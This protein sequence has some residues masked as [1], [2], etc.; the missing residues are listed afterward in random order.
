MMTT[1]PSASQFIQELDVIISKASQDSDMLVI[2]GLYVILWAKFERFILDIIK[3]AD[4]KSHEIKLFHVFTKIKATMANGGQV[5]PSHLKQWYDN[6]DNAKELPYMSFSQRLHELEVLIGGLK[7]NNKKA[8]LGKLK[9]DIL[10]VIKTTRDEIAH[11]KSPNELDAVID[12]ET[13]QSAKD[14]FLK[15]ANLLKDEPFLL[16]EASA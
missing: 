7:D 10:D 5:N 13:L 12:F 14:T 11:G 15:V 4:N 3:N 8:I 2:A 9:R 6:A 16:S 1:P